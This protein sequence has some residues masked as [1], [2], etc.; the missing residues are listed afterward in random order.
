MVAL[1]YLR[2]SLSIFI[3]TNFDNSDDDGGEADDGCYRLPSSVER[4]YGY[5]CHYSSSLLT[6]SRSPPW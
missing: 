1:R 3:H 5:Y 2:M 4:D 6:L